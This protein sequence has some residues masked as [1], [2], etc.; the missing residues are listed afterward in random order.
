MYSADNNKEQRYIKLSSVFF[1]LNMERVVSIE[2]SVNFNSVTKRHVPEDSKFK[3]SFP[4]CL[5]S[6]CRRTLCSDTRLPYYT[7]RASSISLTYLVHIWDMYLLSEHPVCDRSSN[8]LPPNHR[9]P[10]S[11]RSHVQLII[12]G[13]ALQLSLIR[14]TTRSN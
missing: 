6:L 8:P 2:T 3:E 13:V 11:F 9:R 7:V 4:L 14:N 5:C 10:P 1:T 12:V